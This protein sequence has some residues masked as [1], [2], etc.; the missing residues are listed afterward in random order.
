MFLDTKTVAYLECRSERSVQRDILKGKYHSI[1]VDGVGQGG[2]QW[3]ID[4]KSLSQA[5]QDRYYNQVQ[6]TD[7]ETESKLLALTEKQ[8]DEVFARVSVV[9]GYLEFKSSYPKADKTLA[10]L[11]Q[12]NANNPDISLTKTQLH[13]WVKLYQRDGVAG[14]IDRR[15]GWNKGTS[16]IPER[17]QKVFLAY[18]LQEKGTKD[19]GPSIASCYRL[20]QMNFPDIQLPSVEAFK[21]LANSLPLPVKI[22]GRQGEKAY[23]DKC[24]PYIPRN[25]KTIHTNQQWVADNHIFDVLVLYPDGQ[26]GRPW[27]VGWQDMSSRYIV[28]FHM[29]PDNPNSD[30]I[31]DAFIEAVS[32]YGKPE[33]VQLD[34][35]KD[36]VVH[37]LFNRENIYSL[38]N[39]MCIRVTNAIKYNAKS[40]GI[41]RFF[42]TLEYSFCI[43]LPSYIGSDPKKRAE[44]L[45]KTN[46]KMKG[47][48]IPYEEF[49]VYI[50]HAIDDYNNMSHSGDGMDGRTPCQAFKENITVP[51]IQVTPNL[52]AIYAQRRTK[53]ITVG[54][55]GIKIPELDLYYDN[56]QLFP[57]IG[58]KVYAKYKTKD[59][60]S[61]Y[62]FSEEG[63]YICIAE[64]VALGELN[65]DLTKQ[66][67]RELN[68]KKKERRKLLKAVMPDIKVPSVQQLAIESGKYFN[69]PDLKVLPSV[70]LVDPKNQGQAQKIYREEEKRKIDRADQPDQL[71]AVVGGVD[72]KAIDKALSKR[73]LKDFGGG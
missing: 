23:K 70:L 17:M 3:R 15:G 67:I 56:T 63:E 7:K 2:K 25:Y 46:D 44:H 42:N 11:L 4:T 26:V 41:E 18:W 43:H 13:H 10:F 55:N 37:D 69:K 16:V 61:V 6:E 30:H 58:Q 9:R 12:Y 33:V 65:Q 66:Q 64:S 50:N 38:A 1:N 51:L 73:F 29:V 27:V 40:K 45:K 71:K 57:Y 53:L 52:L 19:G 24:E 49:K 22:Y 20:T 31:L 62:V 60:R 48:A 68:N 35:G 72:P 47:I 28:G 32:E 36:Y 54:R 5:A 8:R 39:E 34:N 21:R 14:L 59:V